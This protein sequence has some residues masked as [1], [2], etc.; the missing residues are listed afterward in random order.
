MK[1]AVLTE[2]RVSPNDDG[3]A[4]DL[5]RRIL[6]TVVWIFHSCN[7]TSSVFQSFLLL[8]QFPVI[9]ISFRHEDCERWTD[10]VQN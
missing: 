1:N 9:T 3:F 10:I 5:W 7:R 6:A 4:A 8:V 2:R